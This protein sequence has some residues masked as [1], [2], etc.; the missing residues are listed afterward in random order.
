MQY[1]LTKYL[2][3]D[4]FRQNAFTKAFLE[5]IDEIIFSCNVEALDITSNL[6]FEYMDDDYFLTYQQF[7]LNNLPTS[8]INKLDKIVLSEWF[9]LLHVRG[10]LSNLEKLLKFGGSL[11]EANPKNDLVLYNEADVPE[12]ITTNP[13]NGIIYAITDESV[14]LN[15]DFFINQQTPAGYKIG[16]IKS[17]DPMLL[18]SQ[19][20]IILNKSSEKNYNII[21]CGCIDFS[22]SIEKNILITR[23]RQFDQYYSFGNLFK[24]GYSINKLSKRHQDGYYYF[25][26]ECKLSNTA[27]VIVNITNNI[28]LGIGRVNCD[29]IDIQN[30]INLKP[31][32]YLL[33]GNFET[34]ND[35]YLKDVDGGGGG[36]FVKSRLQQSVVNKNIHGN[37]PLLAIGTLVKR[38]LQQ[39]LVPKQLRLGIEPEGGNLAFEYSDAKGYYYAIMNDERDYG[40]SILQTGGLGQLFAK[41][42]QLLTENELEYGILG[43][44]VHIIVGQSTRVPSGTTSLES[45]YWWM[46]YFNN[47]SLSNFYS[48]NQYVSSLNSGDTG[49]NSVPNS[50]FNNV[51]IGGIDTN[52]P[53]NPLPVFDV[54]EQSRI[55]NVTFRLTTWSS[56][57]E[58]YCQ[59]YVSDPYTANNSGVIIEP[60]PT[61]TIFD[62]IN[63]ALPNDLYTINGEN[64]TWNRSHILFSLFEGKEVFP[65]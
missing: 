18:T 5:L 15:S 46:Y 48:P 65:V 6:S 61:V 3:A 54:A 40:F 63:Y 35:V 9:S 11:S 59:N 34:N 33:S 31:V 12:T 62:L 4:I 22:K 42:T 1:T 25:G 39:T 37:D 51:Y 53:P 8:D 16:V 13:K 58:C 45:Q 7:F 44:E 2:T 26:F 29:F 17:I 56:R 52:D 60:A 50:E 27:P 49:N 32:D 21:D 47:G 20:S 28:Y 10:E 30:K 19:T 23:R 14:N 64:I 36:G 41:Y 57:P 43:E 24:S 38:Q 55:N